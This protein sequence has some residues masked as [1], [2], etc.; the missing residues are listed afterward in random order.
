MFAVRYL[1]WYITDEGNVT[2]LK[3]VLKDSAV[4]DF[5]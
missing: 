2:G 5:I 4:P 1:P 3:A